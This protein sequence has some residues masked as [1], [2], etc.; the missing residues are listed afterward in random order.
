MKERDIKVSLDTA[1]EWYN[2]DNAAL[3]KLAL[4]AFTEKE[5]KSSFKSIKTF[6]DACKV[7]GISNIELRGGKNINWDKQ[8][9][10]DTFNRWYALGKLSIIRKALNKGYKMTLIKN[11][12]YY[13][14]IFFINKECRLYDKEFNKT[15]IKISN[16]IVDKIEY[17]LVGGY[18]CLNSCE[19]LSNFI[20]TTDVSLSSAN[21][22]FLGCATKEIAEHMS[23][24]FAKEIFEAMYKGWVDFEWVN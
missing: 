23:R 3:K 21:V 7:L 24:Y 18:T 6:D 15:L 5:L 11:D 1:T 16:F 9:A 17:T 10:Q 2:G 22:G 4:Q 13:P 12:I 8:D 14:R 20:S 19:G